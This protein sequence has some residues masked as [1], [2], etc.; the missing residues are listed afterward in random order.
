MKLKKLVKYFQKNLSPIT[1]KYL[2][3]FEIY[4]LIKSNKIDDA[5]I[6]LDL[7][8]E[9]GFKDDYFEKKLIIYLVILMK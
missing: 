8:K 6:K 5:Q 1:D 2:S 9:L 4:C 7:K 3:K